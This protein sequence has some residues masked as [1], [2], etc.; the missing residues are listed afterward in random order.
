MIRHTLNTVDRTIPLRLVHASRGKRVRAEPIAALYE[1]HKVHHVGSF[2]DLEDQLCSWVPDVSASPDRLDALV[3][4]LTE[5]M[6]DGARQHAAVA[7]INIEQVNP[8][9][10]Q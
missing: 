7:P 8:W 10:P 3:W 2:P 4:E 1:Q 9:I 5:L 6:I